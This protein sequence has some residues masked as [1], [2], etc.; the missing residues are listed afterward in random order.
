MPI[1]DDHSVNKEIQNYEDDDD[2]VN[3]TLNM[4]KK[5]SMLMITIK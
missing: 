5:K 4:K 3:S 2:D 1:D